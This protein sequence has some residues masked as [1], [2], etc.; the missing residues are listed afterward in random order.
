MASFASLK[1]Q[2]LGKIPHDVRNQYASI[3]EEWLTGSIEKIS[4]LWM[5]DWRK[6]LSDISVNTTDVIYSMPA[7]CDIISADNGVLLD[8]SSLPTKNRLVHLPED[9]FNQLYIDEQGDAE[10]ATVPR[11]F[12]PL[13]KLDSMGRTRIRI[14]PKSDTSRTAR[15]YYYT[16]PSPNDAA[17]MIEDLILYDVYSKMPASIEPEATTWAMRYRQ[18]VQELKPYDEKS[19]A[20]EPLFTQDVQMRKFFVNLGDKQG[21]K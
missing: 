13:T 9:A 21:R 5:W 10:T 16:E 14:Y 17:N 19:A 3:V 7:D 11:Y 4:K 20:S 18:L 2:I 15:I 6:N 1:T 12:V 8:A